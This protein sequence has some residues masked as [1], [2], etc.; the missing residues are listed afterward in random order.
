MWH[1][2][3]PVT[4]PSRGGGRTH[5]N[6]PADSEQHP[7]GRPRRW[8]QS[9]RAAAR[10]ARGSSDREGAMP[11]LT[12]LTTWRDYRQ[13]PSAA[14]PTPAAPA[15]LWAPLR[16][17][18]RPLS[19]RGLSSPG[20]PQEPPQGSPGRPARPSHAHGPP[21]LARGRACAGGRR[22]RPWSGSPARPVQSARRSRERPM[23]PPPPV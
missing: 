6:S 13:A 5:S 11:G 14:P 7:R 19:S 10:P 18:T 9:G 8:Q 12:D 22:G 3:R 16:F 4:S 20:G 1:A 15:C 17:P 23:L 21:G 2:D